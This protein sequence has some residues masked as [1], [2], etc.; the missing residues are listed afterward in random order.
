MNIL[1][2]FYFFLNFC[3][4]LVRTGN[5]DLVLVNFPLSQRKVVG[6]NDKRSFGRC[7]GSKYIVNNKD[8]GFR[9]QVA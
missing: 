4:C 9:F 8:F 3:L 6:L 5:S 2:Q 1:G 7:G